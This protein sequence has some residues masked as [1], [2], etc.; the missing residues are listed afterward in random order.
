MQ[1]GRMPY[2]YPQNTGNRPQGVPEQANGHLPGQ[3]GHPPAPQPGQYSQHDYP[4]N[5]GIMKQAPQEQGGYA[6]PRPNQYP[7]NYR[8]E[9]RPQQVQQTVALPQQPP[10]A[11]NP[12]LA[13]AAPQQAQ[14]SMQNT[15]YGLQP[16]AMHIPQPTMARP[17]SPPQ[18]GRPLHPSMATAAQPTVDHLAGQLQNLSTHSQAG[19]PVG[20]IGQP[21]PLGDLRKCPTSPVHPIIDPGYLR[22]TLNK[23]PKTSAVLHK[24]RLPFGLTVTPY[25]D[26]LKNLPVPSIDGPIVRCRRC[27]TYLNPFVEMIEQGSKWRFPPNYDYDSQTQKYIE[28][29]SK[30][31][32]YHPVYEFIAPMEYMVRPPQPPVYLFL[33]DVSYHSVSSGVL[34]TAARIILDSLD[35]LPNALD[36]TKIGIMT[37]DSTIHFYNLSVQNEDPKLLVVSDL[38]DP[39]LPCMD[40]LLVGVTEGRA[41][42]EKLLKRLATIYANTQDAS[43]AVGSA[44]SAAI[45]LL[46]PIGGKIV[47]I[48]AALPSVGEGRELNR[49]DNSVL[50]TAKE[51]N[52]LQPANSFYKS[53]ATEC[54][55]CQ[56]C[57]DMFLFPMPYLDVATISCA[58]KFTGGSVFLY[59]GF[60]A[61]SMECVEKFAGDLTKF[62]KDEIGLEAVVRIRASQGVSLNAY[63]GSFF[64]RSTDL[65]ALPNVNPQHSY[66]AQVVID[67]NINSQFLCFQ[68]AVLHTN[69]QGE[70][71]IRV[72][73]ASYPVS[74]DPREI[75]LHADVGA[76]TDLLFKMAVEKSLAN[77]LEDARDALLNKMNDIL[78]AI[79]TVFQTGQNPQLLLTEN[80][81]LLPLL[82]LSILKSPAIRGGKSTGLDFRAYFMALAKT[83]PVKKSIIMLHPYI[84]AVHKMTTEVSLP[85]LD[86][87][88]S[89]RLSAIMS[90][91]ARQYDSNP[92][93]IVI[94]EDSDEQLKSTFLLQ[95][96]EDKS[97]DGQPSYTAWAGALRDKIYASK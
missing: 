62:L 23:I 95:L 27:R 34:S 28:R 2:G 48:Q 15:P 7:Q 56:I 72:I 39:F 1:Q 60:S 91:L 40:D 58:A 45:K 66:S 3:S 35:S 88:W 76:I 61:G 47:V 30:A 59:P 8:Q 64:L 68:T 37:V 79:K 36:R 41:Q 92:S 44:M 38:N 32:L 26:H 71:R 69:C 18:A 57:I 24:T 81:R 80:L 65:L 46:A 74:D 5:V 4:P 94:R 12:V 33:L 54:S 70:R 55:R 90:T 96:V 6:P 75:M 73:N 78:L 13:T 49:E 20:I 77:K 14:A 17:M 50:G 43:S 83:V 84:F 19:Q 97:P 31:E 52:L 16:Q 22:V 63:H 25:P 67:E 42:V 53:L 51:N 10:Q 85:P 29:S 89:K 82:I 21:L 87:P 11:Y 86:N 93:T 9:Y